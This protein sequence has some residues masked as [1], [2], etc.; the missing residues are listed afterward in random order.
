[1]PLGIRSTAGTISRLRLKIISGPSIKHKHVARQF[2]KGNEK[3]KNRSYNRGETAEKEALGL[4]PDTAPATPLSAP[5]LV[6][7]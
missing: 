7:H 1:L 4:E 2:A 5:D 6:R 3:E